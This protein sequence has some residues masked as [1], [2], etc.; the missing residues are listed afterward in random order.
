MKLCNISIWVLLCVTMCFS[1]VFADE[2]A[3]KQELI[4]AVE[5][6]VQLIES[7]GQAAFDELSAFRFDNGTGYLYITNYDAVV[8]M[9]PV[10]PELLNKDCTGIRG[11]KGKYFGAEM[12]SKAQSAG[13]GWTHYWWPN[14]DKN[15]EPDIKC[16]YFKVA[17][18]DGQKVIIYAASFGISEK[19]C[20]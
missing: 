20:E 6:G 12:K 13:M 15:G 14:R 3:K 4:D 19:G 10:A 1:N 17:N 16:A 9:H 18:M 8:I 11:A 5:Y 2:N 7:K